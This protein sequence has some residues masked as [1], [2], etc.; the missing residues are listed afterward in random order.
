MLTIGDALQ[1]EQALTLCIGFIG[2]QG[3]RKICIALSPPPPPLPPSRTRHVLCAPLRNIFRNTQT[4]TN[5][6]F[7]HRNSDCDVRTPSN[8]CAFLLHLLRLPARANTH[9]HV[10]R[11][12]GG[13][14]PSWCVQSQTEPWNRGL[15]FCVGNNEVVH[16]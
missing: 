2:H 16:E 13:V 3:E 15:A 11:P 9:T 12:R 10:K 5:T 7:G 1:Y 8:L 14:P 6:F 4:L